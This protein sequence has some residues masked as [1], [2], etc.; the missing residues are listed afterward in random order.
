MN[1]PGMYRS[2]KEAMNDNEKPEEPGMY[3]TKMEALTKIFGYVLGSLFVLAFA[4][5]VFLGLAKLIQLAY[6]GFFSERVAPARIVP[7]EA[8]VNL[9]L[10]AA[11]TTTLPMVATA[12]KDAVRINPPATIPL[13][14][15]EMI[16]AV[17][18]DNLEARAIRIAF[19]ESRY[20][21][22]VRTWCC[23]G[24]MQVH[25]IHLAWLCP[26]YGICTTDQLYDPMTNVRAAYALY[27][28]EAD[29]HH[30]YGWGP[31]ET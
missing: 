11:P 7:A 31:W 26:E 1:E 18:P 24:V 10:P 5:L 8:S 23:F 13:T 16:R 12:T 29:T 4:I 17:W 3:P 28:R 25:K 20:E 2:K 21:C 15:Q 19:R 22:C 14:V 30:G 9:V 27:Q 6:D